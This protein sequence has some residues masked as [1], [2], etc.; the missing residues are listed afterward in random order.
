MGSA[1]PTP[2]SLGALGLWKSI[3]LFLV[4]SRFVPAPLLLSMSTYATYKARR[5]GQ[6]IYLIF[7]P[8]FYRELV[9]RR[10]S[11]CAGVFGCQRRY[12]LSSLEARHS[13]LALLQSETRGID[14]RIFC[15]TR[16]SIPMLS[17]IVS[18]SRHR[19]HLWRYSTKR[20]GVRYIML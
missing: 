15:G 6:A 11:C 4:L 13:S 14:R 8:G 7:I 17:S 3:S 10:K 1:L 5:L 2:C 9:R 19:Q 12:I 20:N 18:H 16:P